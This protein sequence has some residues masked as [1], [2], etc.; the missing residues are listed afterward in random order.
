MSDWRTFCTTF[1]ND[2]DKQ[3]PTTCD[4]VTAKRTLKDLLNLTSNIKI[5]TQKLSTT[6][7]SDSTQRSNVE[8]SLKEKVRDFCCAMEIRESANQQLK[9][10]QEDYNVAKARVESI[11]NPA[12]N[13]TNYGTTFP[14]GRPL[15]SDS[16]PMLFF[17][18]FF[19]LLIAVGMILNLSNVVLIWN[20]PVGISIFQRVYES[21]SQASWTYNLLLIGGSFALAF[22]IYYG[23]AKTKP[24]LLGIKKDT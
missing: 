10:S 3:Y 12:A 20:R 21:F 19:F 18:T 1:P 4:P 13:V 14:L 11:R 8:I 2:M 9:Q 17:F 5:E 22:G 24:E 15:R 16:V 6:N 23:I 7:F